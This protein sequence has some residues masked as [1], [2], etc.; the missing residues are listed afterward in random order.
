M[1]K[2]SILTNETKDVSLLRKSFKCAGLKIDAMSKL[3]IAKPKS[4][5]IWFEID[6]ISLS[7]LLEQD[8][9]QELLKRTCLAIVKRYVDD[10]LVYNL[11]T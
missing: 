6:V 3:T 8:S 10:I 5:V 11:K 4:D 1:A 9:V 2:K 7:Y